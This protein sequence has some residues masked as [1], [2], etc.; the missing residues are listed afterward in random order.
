MW[1]LLYTTLDDLVLTFSRSFVEFSYKV[2]EALKIQQST[3]IVAKM[4]D[5]YHKARMPIAFTTLSNHNYFSNFPTKESF[6]KIVGVVFM[7]KPFRHQA[8]SSEARLKNLS[9]CCS[10][11]K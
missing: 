9:A 6:H 5:T 4:C 7:T 3:L 8:L 1:Q 2:F 11:D 10:I